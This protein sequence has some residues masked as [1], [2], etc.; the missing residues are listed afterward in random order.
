MTNNGRPK[1]ALIVGGGIAG[2]VAAIALRRAGLE[3]IVAEAYDAAA[4][5][6]GA[7]LTLAPNGIRGLRTLGIERAL[8]LGFETPRFRVSLGSGRHLA[9]LSAGRTR[10]ATTRTI[11]RGD[12]YGALRRE[13]E[14]RGIRVEYGKRLVEASRHGSSVAA[15]FEDGTE[16]EA[17]LLVGAD[18]LRSR[19]RA[20]VDPGAAPL[21]YLGLLNTGGYARGVDV[22]DEPG[23]MHMIFGTRCFFGWLRHPTGEVWWF[24]NPARRDEPSK[25]DLAAIAPEAWRSELAAL[26]ADDDSPAAAIVAATPSIIG[27]WATHDLPSARVWHRDRMIVVGDAAHAASPSSG[28]GASMAIEDGIVLAKCLRDEA[29][30]EGAFASYELARRGRV[31]RIVAIGKR[32][33]DGKTP[34]RFGRIVRDLF[35]PFVFAYVAKSDPMA[36]AHDHHIEWDDPEFD[37]V[38]A[39]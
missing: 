4:D 38:R 21:R 18:G 6:V 39:S 16:L 34:G 17:D 7:F 8:D 30:V 19:V 20:L 25:A 10:D 24:A 5:G 29:A 33:G 12:L 37:A 31:E 28:Q 22:P 1:R 36:F 2:T 3:P 35:L 14:A 26:F 13:V 11:R 15:R 9:D 32:N 23:T 27:P